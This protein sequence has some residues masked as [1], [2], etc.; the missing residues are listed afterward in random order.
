MILPHEATCHGTIRPTSRKIFSIPSLT[1]LVCRRYLLFTQDRAA[2]NPGLTIQETSKYKITVETG[3]VSIRYS[4]KIE[5]P[6]LIICNIVQAI[7][8]RL[9]NCIT[10]F[11][12]LYLSETLRRLE[13]SEVGVSS[14]RANEFFSECPVTRKVTL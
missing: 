4:K 2:H 3:L 8:Y 7:E 10:G 6:T 14:L 13:F 5:L 9:F 11:P 12:E 1:R